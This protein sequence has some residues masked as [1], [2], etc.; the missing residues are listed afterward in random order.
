MIKVGWNWVELLNSYMKMYQGKEFSY[1]ITDEGLRTTHSNIT[2]GPWHIFDDLDQL[3]TV[4]RN[5]F[6]VFYK[7]SHFYLNEGFFKDRTQFIRTYDT[8]KDLIETQKT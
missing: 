3:D 6:F 2:Y 4:I 7:D 8:I 1:I 5:D